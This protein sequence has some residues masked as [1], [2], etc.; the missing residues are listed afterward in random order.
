MEA[1]AAADA[2]AEALASRPRPVISISHTYI[3]GGD[4]F[5]GYEYGTAT[6]TYPS[7]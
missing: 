3:S 1:Q 2:K 6:T 5:S 7:H 4:A